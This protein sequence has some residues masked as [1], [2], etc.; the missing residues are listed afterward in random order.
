MPRAAAVGVRV[1]TVG[2]ARRVARLV[3]PLPRPRRAADG[4]P[5]AAA[6]ALVEVGRPV[7]GARVA[8][9][10]RLD[11][12]A[13]GPS[14]G[15]PAVA[16]VVALVAPAGRDVGVVGLLVLP[17]HFTVSTFFNGGARSSR[18]RSLPT[19]VQG[20]NATTRSGSSA[21]GAKN[22]AKSAACWGAGSYTSQSAA[23]HSRPSRGC[24]SRR[25]TSRRRRCHRR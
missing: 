11:P 4:V 15:T 18:S 6:V 13:P 2:F 5:T 12:V 1:A 19:R 14:L 21:T 24:W 16:Q 10:V 20:S 22:A 3:G 9:V 7:P 23:A 17:H 8:A 25:Y